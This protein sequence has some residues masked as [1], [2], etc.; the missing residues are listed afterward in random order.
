MVD[1]LSLINGNTQ[2][3][4]DN[5]NLLTKFFSY[6]L[7]QVQPVSEVLLNYYLDYKGNVTYIENNNAYSLLKLS[8]SKGEI[9]HISAE[10]STMIN[11]TYALYKGNTLVSYYNDTTTYKTITALL[12]PDNVDTLY[13]Q[14]LNNFGEIK[15]IKDFTYLTDIVPL[16]ESI[17]SLKKTIDSLVVPVL[18]SPL[19]IEVANN[20]YLNPNP[21]TGKPTDISSSYCVGSYLIEAGKQYKV[22]GQ[23]YQGNCLYSIFDIKGNLLLKHFI[24]QSDT[25]EEAIISA[26]S[27]S[28]IIYMEGVISTPPILNEIENWIAESKKWDGKKWVT[29]GDSLTE[30]NLRASKNYHDYVTEATGIEVVNMGRS[31]TGYARTRDEGFAFFQRALN[32]PQDADGITIFG[33]GNDLSA[34]LPLG[35]PTDSS[36]TESLCGYIHRTI[37]VIQTN[38]PLIPFGIVTPTPWIGL[39]PSQAPN[40]MSRYSDAI[41]AI[42]K[43]RGVPCFDLYYC[44]NLHPSNPTFR[45]LAYSKDEGNGVHPDEVGQKII[46]PRFL[47]FLDSLLLPTIYNTI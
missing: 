16:Q 40:S 38:F 5:M 26:P 46:A 8:V 28:Y 47:A 2:Y 22:Q 10:T 6:E 19:E 3:C 15:K 14:K 20:K 37:D 34:G 27:D 32:I 11:S 4:I 45:E 9:Y 31:G 39:E 21:T 42:C 44:S 25:I 36:E 24:Q 13:V 12:I 35:E 23:G 1:Y 33:S 43:I 17:S 41:V 7:E 30:F 29:L 18:S